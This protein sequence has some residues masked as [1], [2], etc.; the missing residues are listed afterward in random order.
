MAALVALAIF[1]PRS[2]E[3]S[4]TSCSGPS[5]MPSCLAAFS[6]RAG[7][8]PSATMRTPSLM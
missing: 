4:S 1:T 3:V 6:I 8:T 5:G 7:A 2:I